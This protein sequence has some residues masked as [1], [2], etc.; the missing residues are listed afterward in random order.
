MDFV[1]FAFSSLSVALIV[2]LLAL[3]FGKT[4][5]LLPWRYLIAALIA[6]ILYYNLLLATAREQIIIYYLLNGVPQVL[7]FIILL[8][9]LR[10]KRQ[11]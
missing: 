11:A 4:D 5:R 9:F 7:L 3:L 8:V 1:Y 2:L 6:G 10:R